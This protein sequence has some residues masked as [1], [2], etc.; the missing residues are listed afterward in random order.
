MVAG[1]EEWYIVNE[2]LEPIIQTGSHPF[3]EEVELSRTNGELLDELR[4]ERFF[5]SFEISD[6][7]TSIVEITEGGITSSTTIKNTVGG[8]DILEQLDDEYVTNQTEDVFEYFVHLEKHCSSTG[9]TNDAY[10]F[11]GYQMFENLKFIAEQEIGAGNLNAQD[12]II[13]SLPKLVYLR[14]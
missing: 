1:Q 10:Y 3:F 9:G 6:E 4:S 13:F 14:K 5:E 12:T 2:N 8:K 11:L 7:T